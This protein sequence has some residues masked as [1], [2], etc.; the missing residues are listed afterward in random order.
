MVEKGTSGMM[1][2]F[3]DCFFECLP[4]TLPLERHEDHAIDIIPGSSPSNRAPYRVSLAQQEEIMSQVK[5]LLE[6]GLI[7]P[8]SSPYCS[9]VLLVHKKDGSWR[10]C[11]DY[12]G[13][14]KITIKN[15]F[16][17]PRIDD[18]LDQLE[19]SAILSRIDLKSGYHQIRIQPEDVHKTAFRTTFGLYKF[20]VMLFG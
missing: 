12:K 6:K 2:Q 3:K 7:R 10:M 16:F 11:I 15:Q 19:G 20:L 18:I 17:I 4:D 5:E 9:P 14:N 13:L 1:L 8:S